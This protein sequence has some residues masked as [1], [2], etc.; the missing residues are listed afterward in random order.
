[1]IF[2]KKL[3]DLPPLPYDY[4]LRSIDVV[5]PNILKDDGFDSS[6]NFFRE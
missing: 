5:D 3:C 1:M 6:K 2:K 4:I